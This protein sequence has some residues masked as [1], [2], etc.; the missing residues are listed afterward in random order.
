[1]NLM[2]R[3]ALVLII[4]IALVVSTYELFPNK[5]QAQ[6]EIG[7]ESVLSHIKVG[8][9]KLALVEAAHVVQDLEKPNP[10]LLAIS[11][12]ILSSG[13]RPDLARQAFL[14]LVEEGDL[15]AE[16]RASYYTLIGRTYLDEAQY[17]KAEE[18]YK[19]ALDSAQTVMGLV[20]L[21]IIAI[22]QGQLDTAAQYLAR[23][24]ELDFTGFSRL[25]VAKGD[26]ARSQGARQEALDYYRQALRYD[27]TEIQIYQRL[28]NIY[29]ELGEVGKGQKLI[30]EAKSF[31]ITLAQ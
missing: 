24:E 20:D 26:L 13:G 4:G 23:A 1:M 25:Y 27:P 19:R 15:S 11:G 7:L 18:Y 14:R 22:R 29:Q 28:L 6:R 10:E 9:L 30:E 17:Q 12:M 21:G 2:C 3:R 31:G 5:V 16:E 8:W